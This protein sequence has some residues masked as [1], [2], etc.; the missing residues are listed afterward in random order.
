MKSFLPSLPVFL[1]IA[2]S[3]AEEQQ[4]YFLSQGIALNR[5]QLIDARRAGVQSPEKIRVLRVKTLPQLLNEDIMFIAKQIGL[6]STKSVALT[7]GY[8]I[9]LREDHWDDRYSLVH[10]CVHVSQYEKRNG[11]GAFLQEY[12]RECMDPGYPFGRMEQ[13][14]IIVARDICKATRNDPL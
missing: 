13:E 3:W 5:D 11:I 2:C 7:F 8:G 9:C 10:E 4:K 6:F 1:P 12:L 14:A